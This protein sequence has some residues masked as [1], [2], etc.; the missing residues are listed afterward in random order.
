MTRYEKES[1]GILRKLFHVTPPQKLEGV[2]LNTGGMFWELDGKTD[3][4]AFLN[5]L[6]YLLSKDSI[7]YFE[8][9][10]PRGE[11]RAFLGT[12]SVLEQIH[13]AVGTIWPRPYYYHILATSEILQL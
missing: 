13:I 1:I 7:L 2:H 9:G 12:H 3:F 11:L 5:A 10:A 4:P 8:S 6:D